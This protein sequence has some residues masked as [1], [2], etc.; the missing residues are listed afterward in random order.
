MTAARFRVWRPNGTAPATVGNEPAPSATESTFGKAGRRDDV[1]VR[2]P[3]KAPTI[4][5]RRG[6]REVSNVPWTCLP[7][8][9][10]VPRAAGVLPVLPG[11]PAVSGKKPPDAA[12]TPCLRRPAGHRPVCPR[13]GLPA[14]AAELRPSPPTGPG[15][16]LGGHHRPGR[17]GNALRPGPGRQ[18]GGHRPVVQP[19]AAA[20]QGHQ[21]QGAAPVG[22]HSQ[23]RV[24]DR[25]APGPRGL[26]VRVDGGQGRRGRHT[27]A[28]P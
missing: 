10:G 4:D 24:G 19:R 12:S 8:P 28:V 25:Q 2:R 3:A 1:P 22:Q 26:A 13:C 15:T 6:V 18:G 9:F 16:G 20:V 21:R 17:H 11:V 14:A 7:G 27:R 5:C 23:L